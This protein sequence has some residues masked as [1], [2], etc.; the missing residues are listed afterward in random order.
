MFI[1]ICCSWH[2]ILYDQTNEYFTLL[3]IYNESKVFLYKLNTIMQKYNNA[4]KNK[5]MFTY[6]M[7]LLNEFQLWTLYSMTSNCCFLNTIKCWI[8][9]SMILINIPFILLVVKETS[10]CFLF[11]KQLSYY[12]FVFSFRYLLVFIFWACFYS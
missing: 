7:Q 9:G 5:H 11:R 8:I 6:L 4:D 12:H 3:E 2:D 1:Q 10:H